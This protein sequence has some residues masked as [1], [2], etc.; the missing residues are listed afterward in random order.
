MSDMM[1]YS[2]SEWVRKTDPH[3]EFAPAGTIVSSL[4]A[5]QRMG[6]KTWRG[7]CLD[8]SLVN[9]VSQ[10]PLDSPLYHHHTMSR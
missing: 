9:L 10:L 2:S 1:S 8:S 3:N 6:A 4:R 5:L 7:R